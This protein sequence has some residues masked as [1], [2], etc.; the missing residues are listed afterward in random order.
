MVRREIGRMAGIV[1]SHVRS[2]ERQGGEKGRREGSSFRLL[3]SALIVVIEM[4]A[5]PSSGALTRRS[6]N[7]AC[8]L[9]LRI[10]HT[11]A[12]QR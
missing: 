3:S 4:L 12:P 11:Y 7:A 9:C 5:L 2:G 6:D 1:E 8:V 10:Q